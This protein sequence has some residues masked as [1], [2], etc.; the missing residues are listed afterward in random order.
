MAGMMACL[1]QANPDM[2]NMEL[3]NAVEQSSSI[4]DDPDNKVGYGIPDFIAADNY[5][6]IIEQDGNKL[7]TEAQ[8]Y[9]N[10]F[11]DHFELRVNSKENIIARLAVVDMTGRV[12]FEREY[13][14]NNGLNTIRINELDQA[15]SGIYFLRLESGSSVITSK[16]IRQ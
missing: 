10:P 6:G 4:A 16:L 1:W 15:P 3:I 5:L 12:I 9:P 14:I 8:L 7:F 13:R 11:S 2:N